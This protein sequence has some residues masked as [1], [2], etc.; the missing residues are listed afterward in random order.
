M[1]KLL[2]SIICGAVVL[3]C[4]T[5]P[6]LPDTSIMTPVLAL[7]RLPV[8]FDTDANNELDDQ[9]ALAYLLFN[10][11]IFDVRGITVNATFNG[12][13]IQEQYAEADRV[14][15]LCRVDGIPLYRGADSSF[16][17]IKATLDQSNFD[18]HVAV[19]F[20]I[21]E[22]RTTRDQTLVLLPVGKLTNIALALMKAPDIKSKVRIVWLGSNYPEP[23]EYNQIND[24][25]S[26]NYILEQEVPFEM[27]MVRYGKPSGSDMVRVTPQEIRKKMTGA[28][29]TTPPVEGRHGDTFTNFGDYSVDLFDHVDL[30][31]DPPSRALFD[32]V[33]VAILKN[34]SW[35]RITEIE[36]PILQGQEWEE[37]PEN[38]RKISI[39]ENFKAAE[40]LDDFYETMSEPVL[41]TRH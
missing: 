1:E 5:G 40:I 13:N 16:D 9:H 2:L 14:M 7:E 32:M 33:A 35:G 4:N 34:S 38:T 36:A 3:A 22:A 8:I 15:K 41:A 19:D 30:H 10:G 24:I 39:W 29:P 11:D 6:E 18:G 31:G 20:I 37:R 23:G 27:V 12:G 17:E 26:L 25:P 21:E 28:G